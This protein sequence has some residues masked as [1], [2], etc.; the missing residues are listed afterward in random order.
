VTTVRRKWLFVAII[1][2]G[3][4]TS[5]VAVTAPPSAAVT[6]VRTSATTPSIAVQLFADQAETLGANKYPDSFAGATLT[7]TGV[8]DVYALLASDARLVSAIN[9]INQAG[10]PVDIIGVSRSYNQ[11]NALNARLAAADAHLMKM[12]IKLSQSWP[13][14]ASASVMVTVTAPSM[15][16][17]SAL[18]SV[19]DS[20]VA[21]STYPRAVSDV[22]KSEFGSS[23]TLYSQ[24]GGTWVAAGRNNDVAP[25]DDGDQIYGGGA[26]CTGGFNM[27]GNRSGHVFMITAG[28]C[29]STTWSTQAQQVGTTSTNYLAN[30]GTDHDY[31]TI[32]VPK[33]GID[34]VWGAGG[35]LYTVV[36]QLLPAPGTLIAF[37]GS[38]TNEVRDNTVNAINETVYNIY[39]SIHQCFYNAHPVVQATNPNG[40]WICRPGDSGGPVIQHTPSSFANV[41]A[42]GTIV[43]YFSTGGAGGSTCVAAQ[44]GDIESVTN[45]TLLSG[46]CCAAELVDEELRLAIGKHSSINCQPLPPVT[47]GR[48]NERPSNLSSL[49]N[50]R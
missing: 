44:I 9:A 27:I 7:P 48:T 32:Y 20:P 28:H 50:I 17:F 37:D 1:G 40:T 19:I 11:L 43:A 36:G 23:V 29:P 15:A 6:T 16:D 49:Q 13:D 26:T 39:D 8:T 33:G 21:A 5:A 22:L 30:C 38:V 35:A 46:L 42:V 25:F 10:Y 24:D 18:A 3:L 47:L 12:G 45:T 41:D 14:P 2:G 31:Q 34:D 4:L